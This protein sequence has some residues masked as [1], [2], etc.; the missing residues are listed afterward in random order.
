MVLVVEAD[1]RMRSQ[2]ATW[3]EAEGYQVL[4]CPGPTGPD[5][6]CVMG[7]CRRCALAEAANLVV[8]DTGLDSNS[9]MEGTPPD[10]LLAGYLALDLPVVVLQREEF[11]LIPPDER[12]RIVRWPPERKVLLAVVRD[13]L[14]PPWSAPGSQSPAVMELAHLWVVGGRAR[15]EVEPGRDEGGLP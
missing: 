1:P 8:L 12:V 15:R 10:E 11:D 6:T 4:S 3:L 2:V 14:P 13:L 9:V 7:R 5:Y